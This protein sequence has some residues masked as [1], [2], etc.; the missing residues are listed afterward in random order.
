[1]L[2]ARTA[3]SASPLGSRLSVKGSTF[4][5]STGRTDLAVW[6]YLAEHT[7]HNKATTRWISKYG[8]RRDVLHST[9]TRVCGHEAALSAGLAVCTPCTP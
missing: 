9:V 8:V 2:H 6:L 3:Q 1:M 4:D 7:T 5:R